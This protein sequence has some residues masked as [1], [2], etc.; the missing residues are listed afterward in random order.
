[1]VKQQI[2]L[3]KKKTHTEQC[4]HMAKPKTL[5]AG[6]LIRYILHVLH[7]ATHEKGGLNVV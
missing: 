1:M 4:G 2:L 3:Q 6:C 7:L 5:T